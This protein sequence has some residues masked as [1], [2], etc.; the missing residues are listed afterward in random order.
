MGSISL[1]L[2]SFM[3]ALFAH[4][5]RFTFYSPPSSAGQIKPSAEN[6]RENKEKHRESQFILKN[7]GREILCWFDKAKKLFFSFREHSSRE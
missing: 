7:S 1:S 6:Q 3:L 4:L 5:V 2:D